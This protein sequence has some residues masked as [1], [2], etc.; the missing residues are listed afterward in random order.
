MQLVCVVKKNTFSDKQGNSFL[1]WS[2][3]PSR[4]NLDAAILHKLET[5]VKNNTF[6]RGE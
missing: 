2:I 5:A 3:N 6:L 4:G 1:W